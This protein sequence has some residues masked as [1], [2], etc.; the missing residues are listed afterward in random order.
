ML[1][2]VDARTNHIV[3]GAIPG[4]LSAV[5]H[6]AQYNG[7]GGPLVPIMMGFIRLQRLDKAVDSRAWRW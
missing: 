2:K 7:A 1:T 5:V 6:R 4:F 3:I